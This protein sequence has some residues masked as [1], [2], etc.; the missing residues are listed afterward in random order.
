MAQVDVEERGAEPD[1]LDP[2]EPGVAPVAGAAPIPVHEH[3]EPVRA[4]DKRVRG[5]GGEVDDARP[6]A[7]LADDV[8]ARVRPLPRSARAAEHE[9]DLLVVAVRVQRRRLAA[10]LDSDA[11][12]ADA[13]GAGRLAQIAPA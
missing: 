9:E 4:G 3:V 10:G 6:G 11:V 2:R 1:L 12:D 5:P 7:D 8:L 13:D